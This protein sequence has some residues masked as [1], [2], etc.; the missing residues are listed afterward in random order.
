MRRVESDLEEMQSVYQREVHVHY[1]GCILFVYAHTKQVYSYLQPIYV[2]VHVQW[3]CFVLQRLHQAGK[4]EELDRKLRQVRFHVAT[5]YAMLYS[6]V[7]SLH[8]Q[9]N[10]YPCW[11]FTQLEDENEKLKATVVG[12]QDEVCSISRL[13]VYLDSHTLCTLIVKENKGEAPRGLFSSLTVS[14]IS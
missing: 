9:L 8:W 13:C 2:H 6:G 3:H 7:W 11:Y 10:F 4:N 12:L 14:L 5:S 1:C